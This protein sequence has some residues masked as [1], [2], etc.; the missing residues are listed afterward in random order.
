[1]MRLSIEAVSV[2]APGL[3]GWENSRA[4][5]AGQSAYRPEPVPAFSPDIL[6]PNERRRITPTIRIALQAAAAALQDSGVAPHETVTVFASESGD[7]DVCDRVCA[8]LASPGRPV[9]PTDF[10]NSV[11]N[12][13]A[14]YWAIG[15]ACRLPSTSLSAGSASFSAGLIEAALLALGG[16]HPVLLLCYESGTPA[17]L[18]RLWPVEQP[19]ATGIVL[20]RRGSARSLGQLSMTVTE[21]T[22]PATQSRTAKLAAR[23]RHNSGAAGLP[24]LET[25]A[26]GTTGTCRLPY[27]NGAHVLVEFRPC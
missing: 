7:L 16:E 4:I 3:A 20:S 14:G 26:R 11:H 10:H 9:S 19:F 13:P 2:V 5:L 21:G 23:L 1:M 27:L 12:A 15:N 25:L 18:T 6:P 8:A 17:A 24:L 22:A